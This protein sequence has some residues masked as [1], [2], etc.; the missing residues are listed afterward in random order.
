MP[1]ISWQPDRRVAPCRVIGRWQVKSIKT[2]FFSMLI[3]MVMPFL[4]TMLSIKTKL[5]LGDPA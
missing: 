1:G 4:V 2:N 5:N 3:G